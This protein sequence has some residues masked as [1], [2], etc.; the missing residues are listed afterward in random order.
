MSKPHRH[1]YDPPHGTMRA[2]LFRDRPALPAPRPGPLEGRRV[3]I[4]IAPVGASGRDVRVLGDRLSRAGAVVGV[5]SECQGE[6][7][8]EHMRPIYTH[9]LLVE[10]RPED[11]DLLVFAG[12]SGSARVAQD[13]LAQDLA[14]AFVSAGRPVAAVGRG[15]GVLR[16]ARVSGAVFGDVGE[17]VRRLEP[18]AWRADLVPRAS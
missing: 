1:L 11:W 15:A 17:L 3:L 9:R 10:I 18:G 13:A 16:A 14:R 7:R 12:G 5:A 6:A 8:D 4:I 2:V